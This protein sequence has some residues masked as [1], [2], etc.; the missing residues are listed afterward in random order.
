MACL[1]EEI[2]VGVVGERGEG[3]DLSINID[4]ALVHRQGRGRRGSG[5][6]MG[7]HNAK[8]IKNG[9]CMCVC[10]CRQEKEKA[11]VRAYACAYMCTS[12]RE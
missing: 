9:V 3:V 10:V 7:G 6:G 4:H 11:V 8:P 5:E 12:V 2:R 1:L